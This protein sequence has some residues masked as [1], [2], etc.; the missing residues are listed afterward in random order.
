MT[1]YSIPEFNMESLEKKLTR[2]SNKCR[3]YG[4][5]FHYQKIGEHFAEETFYDEVGYDTAHG[6]PIYETHTEVVRY[7][8]IEVEGN[9]EVNG[10][11][12]AASLEYTEKGN[13][14]EGIAGIQIPSMYYF[15]KPYCEHC[16]TT[17]DRRHSFIVYNE[18]TGEYKQVGKSCLKDFTGGLSAEAAAM[19]ESFFKDLENASDCSRYSG[20]RRSYYEVSEFMVYLAETIRL[21]GYRKR[22]GYN[23]GTADRAEE[24]YRG[25]HGRRTV[26]SERERIEE[27]K[28]RGF[29][30]EN[31]ES[32]KLAK[33]VREWIL[34]S[35]RD[36]NYFHN[37]KVACALEQ[38]DA[39][40]TGLL[41]SSFP[42][43]NREL[44]Y[45][46]ERKAREAREAAA[47]ARSSW[48]GEVGQRIKFHV[49]EAITVTSWET[50]YGTTYVYK[51]VDEE[52]RQATWK[53]SVCLMDEEIANHTVTGTI[54]ELKEFRG[55]KQTE[56]TR[57]KVA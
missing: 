57:C 7:I 54:K 32:V 22:D 52:G 30:V 56:L 6:C 15:C 34:N 39:N 21:Y 16:K 41:A 36:D 9:A 24:L 38:C 28:D 4:C 17:R 13:I 46:A 47:R 14:I 37:L 25:A 11:Q 53:T 20:S 10:W 26:E 2:I 5:S 1:T 18:E 35:D 23:V 50:M 51:M 44:E 55:V 43:Y 29:N 3:K 40:V 19:S 42:A 33:T 31:P 49:T 45:E 48:M 12:Y 8:D 27:A